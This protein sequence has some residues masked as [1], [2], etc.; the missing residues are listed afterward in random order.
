VLP[1]L[2]ELDRPTARGAVVERDAETLF[3]PHSVARGDSAVRRLLEEARFPSLPVAY[4][5][6]E[7]R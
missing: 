4:E 6:R 5:A 7:V 1:A 2:A 3:V